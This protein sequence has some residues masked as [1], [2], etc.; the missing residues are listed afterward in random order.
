MNYCLIWSQVKEAMTVAEIRVV[1][2]K[3]VEFLVDF[4]PFPQTVD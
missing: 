4:Y 2:T 1:E 3:D